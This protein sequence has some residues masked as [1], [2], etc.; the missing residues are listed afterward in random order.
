MTASTAQTWIVRERLCEQRLA[1]PFGLVDLPSQPAA[2]S[3][4][5]I[6]QKIDVMDVGD[7]GIDNDRRRFGTG[8]LVDDDVADEIVQRRH[9]AVVAVGREVARTAQ[10]RDRDRIQYAIVD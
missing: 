6:G 1:A 9:P 3:Q 7:D 8:E 10:A 2:G 4:A 5:G